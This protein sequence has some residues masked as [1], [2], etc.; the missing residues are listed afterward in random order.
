MAFRLY[1]YSFLIMGSP[2]VART[3]QCS[4]HDTSRCVPGTS[5]KVVAERCA[6]SGP[7]TRLFD[8]LMVDFQIAGYVA[9]LPDN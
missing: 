7:P 8:R 6:G 2:H 3:H 1:S 4:K 9:P 5:K